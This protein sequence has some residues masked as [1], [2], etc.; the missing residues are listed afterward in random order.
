MPPRVAPITRTAI[1]DLLVVPTAKS[2]LRQMLL[3]QPLVQQRGVTVDARG[4]ERVDGDGDELLARK[5]LS[6]GC[7]SA[8]ALASSKTSSPRVRP[9]TRRCVASLRC[10]GPG[11]QRAVTPQR[12][13]WN[14]ATAAEGASRA[15]GGRL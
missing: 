8:I 7:R 14:Q 11:F 5:V 4:V 13:G 3:P 1:L 15:L 6:L 10:S 9:E 12:G 2:T